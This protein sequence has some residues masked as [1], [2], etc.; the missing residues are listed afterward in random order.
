VIGAVEVDPFA[1]LGL[2]LPDNQSRCPFIRERLANCLLDLN[3]KEEKF[4]VIPEN[5]LTLEWSQLDRL[6]LVREGVS[7]AG[8][9]KL[10]GFKA[11]GG[12]LAWID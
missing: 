5:L 12:C 3:R 6:L 10:Q 7:S 4:R 2:L 9:R 1:P 11:A 8:E